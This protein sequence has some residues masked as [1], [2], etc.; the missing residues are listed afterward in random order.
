MQDYKITSLKARQ[1]YDSRGLPTV[2]V[3]LE[4]SHKFTGR[5]SVPSGASVGIYEAIE[6]RDNQPDFYHGKGVSKALHNICHDIS[7]YILGK[8]FQTQDQLDALL[9]QLDGSANKSNLGANSILGVSMAFAKAQTIA[10]NRPLYHREDN[11]Y[12]LPVPMMNLINGGAHANN[13][14][15]IQEFMIMP[16]GFETFSDALRAGSEILHSLKG[17]LHRCKLSTSVGDEG[18]FAPNLESEKQALDILSDAIE[19][20]GYQPGVDVFLALDVAAS[21]FYK[22]G[23]YWINRDALN[24]EEFST[25]LVDLITNFPVF[26]IEDPYAENDRAAWQSFSESMGKKVQIVGD[27]LLASSASLLRA[28][29]QDKIAN[30]I[31]IKPNQVGTLTEIAD[32]IKLAAK[33]GYNSIM[34]HRSGETEDFVI[35]HLAMLY[36][37][38]QI[39][40]GALCRGERVIKYNELLRIE[41][42]LGNKSIF[43]GEKLLE[44]F[45]T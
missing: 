23:K 6:L 31:L 43:Y 45:I 26:S 13:N 11:D 17:I 41:E 3:D 44:H 34:S 10:L 5:S 37:I 21:S 7:A 8:T 42:S 2:E 20:A 1:I 15:V 4:L 25:F 30:A 12:I 35:A 33:H 24:S 14:L 38:G 39:K 29:I 19:S 9:I 36:K 27:D 28:A 16:A 18:G 22:N 40:T 32:S